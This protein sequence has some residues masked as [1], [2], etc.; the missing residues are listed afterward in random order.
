MFLCRWLLR[1]DWAASAAF[2][3]LFLFVSAGLFGIWDWLGLAI[4]GALG[5][6]LSYTLLRFGFLAV[7][8]MWVFIE[9]TG[10]PLTLG[11][12]CLVRRILLRH[13]RCDLFAGIRGLPDFTGPSA[14][15][16]GR[17][18]RPAPHLAIR[19]ISD[20]T[21]VNARSRAVESAAYT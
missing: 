5:L 6:L 13:L 19:S 18:V 7:A 14:A 4:F 11:Y 1:K 12:R 17:V 3:L 20:A 10:F 16:V 21:R 15:P 8:A 2:T 9:L